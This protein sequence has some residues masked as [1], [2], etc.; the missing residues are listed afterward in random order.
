MYMHRQESGGADTSYK[1]GFAFGAPRGLGWLSIGLEFG[2]G[3][4]LMACKFETCV[5]LQVDSM[6]P[7]WDALSPSLSAPPPLGLCVK[8]NK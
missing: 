3:R 5:R 4:D 2:S 6:Q 1:G 7:A 8:V